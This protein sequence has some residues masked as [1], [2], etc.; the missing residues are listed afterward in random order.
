MSGTRAMLWKELREILTA[1][2]RPAVQLVVAGVFDLAF[3][4]GMP[5][6]VAAMFR[7]FGFGVWTT[8]GAMCGALAAFCA[9]IG[10]LGPTPTIADAFA[11][12]RERH[13]LETLLAGP[14]SDGAILRGKMAAQYVVVGAH[15]ALV[16]VVAGVTAAV[17]VGLPGLLVLPAGLVGGGVVAGLTSSFIIGLGVLLSLR[18]PTV[19]KAQE[20]LGLVMLPFF[21]LPGLG[22]ALLRAAGLSLTG[23][24][25][26]VLAFAGPA[27]FLAGAVAFNVLAFARFRR[28]RLVGLG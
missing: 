23:A 19:K 24:T 8:V 21:M 12:E 27:F 22:P 25:V 4:V 14:L 11:G 15:V 2:G 7:H 18:S 16:S 10:F 9:F 1:E 6:F 3:G 5:L 20:R 26:W 28:D 17:A 13:T